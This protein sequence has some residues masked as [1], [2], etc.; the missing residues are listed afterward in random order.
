[1]AQ[2][3]HPGNRRTALSFHT[4]LEVLAR[5]GCNRAAPGTNVLTG[6]WDRL[7]TK[8]SDITIGN[9]DHSIQR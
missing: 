8:L 3:A 4:L 7:W 9:I 2:H 1:M 6:Q 5:R